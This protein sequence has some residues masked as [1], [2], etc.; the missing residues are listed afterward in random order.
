MNKTK[1]EK[2]PVSKIRRSETNPRKRFPVAKLRELK[3]SMRISGLISP[4]TVRPVKGG[5]EIVA[6]ECRWRCAKDL[7]WKEVDCLVREVDDLEMA[8]IQMAENVSR[9][10]LNAIEESDGVSRMMELCGDAG[11]VADRLGLKKRWVQGRL[12]LGELPKEARKAV[13]ADQL[14]IA[15]AEAILK[16]NKTDR[17]E[18]VQDLL[19]F[20]DELTTA[21]V[22]DRLEERYFRPREN[23]KRWRAWCAS[24]SDEWD[25]VAEFLDDPER[26]GEFIYSYGKPLGK[27]KLA[28]DRLGNA[29]AR[30]SDAGMTWGQL[31]K[32]LGIQGLLVPVGGV[33]NEGFGNVK[34]LVDGGKIAGVEKAAKKAGEPYTL[35]KRVAE[36]RPVD[37]VEPDEEENRDGQDEQDEAPEMV[38]DLSRVIEMREAVWSPWVIKDLDLDDENVAAIFVALHTMD[39]MDAGWKLEVADHLRISMDAL[40]ELVERELDSWMP[41]AAWWV[42]YGDRSNV[43]RVALANRFGVLDLWREGGE[44]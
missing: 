39:A 3:D 13:A 21:H 30:E 26:W 12:A 42:L 43:Q 14:S 11:V 16:V 24:A 38:V 2:V 44:A 36:T 23:L 33:V 5:F 8:T 35:G 1:I 37:P 27:W 6:G 28:E 7:G 40:S 32:A 18:A 20:G 22:L 17:D 41:V 29:A 25:G 15:A 10:E 19:E 31:A 4:L 34:M 9:R